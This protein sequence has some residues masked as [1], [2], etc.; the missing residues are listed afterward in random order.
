LAEEPT[1]SIDAT[2]EGVAL[3]ALND[4]LKAYGNV[5]AEG[6]TFSAYA[7]IAA[8]K[9]AFD[10]YVKPLFKDIRVTQWRKD[11]GLTRRVWE[12]LVQFA[13]KILENSEKKQVATRIPLKGRFDKPQPDLWATIGGLLRN[14]FIQAL[15]PGIEDSVGA[16]LE[17]GAK[18]QG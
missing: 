15:T 7:E 16:P 3:P 10:G 1:F 9:G 12:G 17:S 8:Q 4:F 14:A 18:K 2:L 13:A 5:D 6:G 11:E